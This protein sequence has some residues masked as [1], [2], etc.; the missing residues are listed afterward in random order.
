MNAWSPDDK[1][2]VYTAE[3]VSSSSGKDRV[4]YVAML[5]DVSFPTAD[6][7]VQTSNTVQLSCGRTLGDRGPVF[8][9]DGKT[10]AYWAWDTNHNASLWLYDRASQKTWPQW[11]RD[12]KSLLFEQYQEG[13]TNL[14]LMELEEHLFE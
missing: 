12:G 9:P 8:S 4:T 3:V 10:I 1:S 11:S 14:W 2:I 5:S 13:K 7:P 6:G